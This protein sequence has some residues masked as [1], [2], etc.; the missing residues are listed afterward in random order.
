VLLR[1]GLLIIAIA[2]TL[3]GCVN[4][5]LSGAQVAYSHSGIQK[6]LTDSYITMQAYHRLFGITH[7]FDNSHITISTFNKKVLMTGQIPS[8][9]ER[10]KIENIIKAIPGIKK[11]YDATEVCPPSSALT[12]MSD[13][14]ITTKIKTHLIA[15]NEIDPD[16][17]KVITE[18]GRVFL[19]GTVLQDHADIAVDIARETDGVQ[20]VVKVFSYLTIKEN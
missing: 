16:Q 7:E 20:S 5:A 3:A 12:R 10:E 14:W 2:A 4:V 8:Q 13:S 9:E 6:N 18:N 19:M 17:I 11:L 1:N 15:M